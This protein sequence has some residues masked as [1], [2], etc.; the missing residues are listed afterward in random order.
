LGRRFYR[1]VVSHADQPHSV[2]HSVEPVE[3]AANVA[4]WL[5]G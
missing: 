1:A 3:K 4:W 2:P 5:C